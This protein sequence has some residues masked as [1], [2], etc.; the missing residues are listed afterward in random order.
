MG[1]L[2]N[3]CS[4][5]GCCGESNN[6]STSESIKHFTFVKMV[7]TDVTLPCLYESNKK[8]LHS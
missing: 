6:K 1:Q 8:H 2:S 3:R 7:I 5:N 4:G